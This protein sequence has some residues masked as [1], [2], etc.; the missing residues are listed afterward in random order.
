MTRC[1]FSAAHAY[2][3]DP[4]VAG[5]AR[6]H[7][8]GDRTGRH[9]VVLGQWRD[10]PSGQGVIAPRR[11]TGGSEMSTEQNKA[12]VRRFITETLDGGNVDVIDELFAPNYVNRAM[13]G[14]DVAGFKATLAAMAAAI[15]G[16]TFEIADLVAE[17]DAVVARFTWAY[18]LA[19]GEKISGRGLTYYGLANGKITE[20]DPI[21]TPDLMQTLGPLLAPHNA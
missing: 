10:R 17:G 3:A 9:T 11:V 12:V 1:H 14:M 19:G 4:G 8:R 5:T 7:Q 15:P 18:T 20:D 21:T 6:S 16:R 13:G 2:S